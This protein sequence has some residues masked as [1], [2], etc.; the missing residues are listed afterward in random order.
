MPKI[1]QA[2]R[3]DK[4]SVATTLVFVTAR[5]L[6]LGK[7]FKISWTSADIS[8][9][10]GSYFPYVSFMSPLQVL[11]SSLE[12]VPFFWFSGGSGILPYRCKFNKV[13]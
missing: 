7:V 10:S 9:F 12:S 8:A 2:H 4:G 3:V 13:Q 5:P 1:V 11:L 6:V